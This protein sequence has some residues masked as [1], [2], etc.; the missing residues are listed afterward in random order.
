MKTIEVGP[1]TPQ[2][3]E[4][5]VEMLQSQRAAFE[6]LK[7]EETEKL[8]MKNDYANVVKK[9]EYRLETYLGQIFY[10]RITQ[11]DFDKY[12][13]FLAKF[14]MATTH[15][16]NPPELQGDTS[17]VSFQAK[18]KKKLQGVLAGSIVFLIFC[19]FVYWSSD[20]FKG[21]F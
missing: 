7:D 13:N 14:G 18:E 1:F 12:K 6:I 20:I 8:Q 9:A 11:D 19:I 16:E 10:I 5:V 2:E 3:L 15:V 17:E 21:L 4:Q